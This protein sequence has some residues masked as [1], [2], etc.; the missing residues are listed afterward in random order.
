V[1]EFVD[2]TTVRVLG[3]YE[4]ELT[5]ADGL[6]TTIDVE[7]YLYGPV[8]EPLRRDPAVFATVTVDPEAGTIERRCDC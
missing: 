8:F 4:L 7:P 5:W 3:G 2:V 6:V 1:S